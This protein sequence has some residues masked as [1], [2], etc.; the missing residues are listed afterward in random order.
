MTAT[1]Q[2]SRK[3]ILGA[4]WANPLTSPYVVESASWVHVFADAVEL[5]Q[6]VDYTVTNVLNPAGYAVT[7]T[8]PGSW[9]PTNW[10][11]NATP[12]VNQ[13]KD[14]TVGG[15][16][17]AKYEDGLD[18][19]TRRLQYVYDLAK[20]AVKTGLSVDPA[21]SYV[22]PV[23]LAGGIIGW[24]DAGTGLEN[25]TLASIGAVVVLDDAT[26]AAASH[27]AIPSQ[28]SVKTYVDTNIAALHTAAQAIAGKW[29][30][31]TTVGGIEML[32]NP[33]IAKNFA[34]QN[35]T[36]GFYS[37]LTARDGVEA[38]VAAHFGITSAT[39]AA[40]DTTHA[41]K[42]A[43]A[44][45]TTVNNGSGSGWGANHVVNV[46]AGGTKR[47]GVALEL[48]VNNDWGNYTGSPSNPYLCGIAISATNNGGY[49]SAAILIDHGYG[50]AG[51][52]MWN[53][54]LHFGV[55]GFK[56]FNTAAIWDESNSPRIL[57]ATGTHAIAGIDFTTATF[58]TA[59]SIAVPGTTIGQNVP[60]IFTGSGLTAGIWLNQT[61]VCSSATV[62]EIG[63]QFTMTSN[64]G[65]ANAGTAYKIALTASVIGGPN[66]AS[67][68]SFN[69]ITQGYAGPGGYLVSGIEADINNIGAAAT[70][71]GSSTAAYGFVSVAAGNFA[72]TAAYWATHGGIGS[73][74]YGFAVT[75][76]CSGAAFIDTTTASSSFAG[77][78]GIIVGSVSKTRQSQIHGYTAANSLQ[79]VSRLENDNG[80]SPTAALG[81]Q[82]TTSGGE[83]RSAK[84]GMGLTRTAANGVGTLSIFN[85]IVN[86]TSDF[87]TAAADVVCSWNG[88]NILSLKSGGVQVVGARDT[89]WGA[90][91]GTPDKATAFATSTVTLAQLAGRVMSLQAALTTHGLIGA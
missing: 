21:V 69:T 27:T 34:G 91:T 17:G 89:G 12:P 42:M 14:L 77:P 84:A 78:N 47:G 79:I 88:A 9:A 10:V 3:V 16:F 76:N 22:L 41:Y 87:T 63:G 51:N 44:T 24:N 33:N 43:L 71:L 36:F 39:G 90:M 30:F 57:Y 73:W 7:I 52:P 75:G 66:S 5:V 58:G 54:G 55:P 29:T 28:Y 49:G 82:V 85:R 8:N 72:S 31:T 2:S 25:K 45:T 70:A 81:F 6:G 11:L 67:V 68:Y 60:Q 20:R 38:E 56:V 32:G 86:D 19:T 35:N 83:T 59:A 50:V 80:G 62:P 23:V 53:C 15:T 1:E 48:N 18:K 37:L 4:G 13:E 65:L 46:G 64:T 40:P 26:L 61:G 74:T